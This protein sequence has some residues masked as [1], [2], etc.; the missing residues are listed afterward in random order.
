MD[1]F[2]TTT[3]RKVIGLMIA[4]GFVVAFIATIVF[5]LAGETRQAITTVS[6]L[7]STFIIMVFT[8]KT[9]HGNDAKAKT[10]AA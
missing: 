8:A 9:M 6:M 1:I 10:A 2:T 7:I 4:L 5:A 3:K